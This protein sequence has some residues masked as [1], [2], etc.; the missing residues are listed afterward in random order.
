M[1]KETYILPVMTII[2]MSQE[3]V[4]CSSN[5]DND[6]EFDSFDSNARFR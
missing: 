5:P 4:I 2:F 1:E 6:V 3:D